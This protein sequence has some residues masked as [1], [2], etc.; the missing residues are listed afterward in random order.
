MQEVRSGRIAYAILSEGGL[1]GVRPKLHAIPW[2][3]LTLDRTE[4]RFYVD[5]AAQRIKEDPGF[6]KD[7]WPSMADLQW[8]AAI[9]EYYN[10]DPYWEAGPPVL[11][12]TTRPV[13]GE[14]AVG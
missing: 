11:G 10:H 5:V 7:H 13:H 8:A 2:S 12:L 3:A 6:D 14:P 4:K 1:P 9:H